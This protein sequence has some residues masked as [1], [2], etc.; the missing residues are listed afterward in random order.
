[1]S[2]PDRRRWW[3]L[4]VLGLVSAVIG[5]DLMVLNVAL[6][7]LARDLDASTSNL[8]WFANAYSLV[9]AA[10][11][12]PAGMLGDRYGRKRFILASL[13]VFGVASLACAYA[14]SAGQ[15]IGARVVLGLGAAFLMPLTMSVLTVIFFEP[16]ERARAVTILVTGNAL[17][18]PLGPIVGGV[19]LDHFWWGSVFLINIPVVV[20]AVIAAAVLLPESRDPSASRLDVPGVALSSAGLVSLTYGVI[21]VG[22]AGWSD[23]PSLGWVALGAVLLAAFVL[24]QRRLSRRPGGQPLVD[25]GLFRSRGFTWGVVTATLANFAMFGIFFAMPQFFQ[26]VDGADALGIGLRLLPVIVGLLVG[27]R[28][29][30]RLLRRLGSGV[31]I[32]IGFVTFAVGLAIGGLMTVDSG[33]GFVATW[34][35]IVG[36]GLGLAL[37]ASMNA[38]L[39]ELSPQRS[40]VG[41]ALIQAV[42]QVG[43]AIGVALLGTV[44]NSTYRNAVDVTGLPAQAADAVRRGVTA[45]VAVADQLG[46][47]TL[48]LSVQDAFVDA[49]HALLFACAGVAVLGAVLGLLF[50]PRRPR[51]G[52]DATPPFEAGPAEDRAESGADVVG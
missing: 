15:L 32:A 45:G 26:A 17:G 33:F 35:G 27:A 23:R 37:P 42:R 28:I 13:V 2:S 19:L 10:A 20:L 52:A 50:M 41:A 3:A 39:G 14:Q 4:G 30:D 12:L 11:L 22:D 51:P 38:A 40:G 29:G 31:V 44:L 47:A 9:L 36:V 48:R 8:Q 7:T 34:F 21:K 43:G 25:V 1:M 46:S 16:V 5:L 6:P 49:T 24:W 18:L